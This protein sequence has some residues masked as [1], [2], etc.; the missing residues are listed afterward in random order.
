MTKT[1]KKILIPETSMKHMRL[2]KEHF[3]YYSTN[4]KNVYKT[5]VDFTS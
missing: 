4:Y 5:P 1:N 2:W 3:L